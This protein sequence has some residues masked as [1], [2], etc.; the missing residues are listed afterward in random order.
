ME[1]ALFS[2]FYL[3]TLPYGAEEPGRCL[4]NNQFPVLKNSPWG[5]AEQVESTPSQLSK[6]QPIANTCLLG[7]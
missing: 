2:S 5:C 1:T 4:D 7:E 6:S 3:R